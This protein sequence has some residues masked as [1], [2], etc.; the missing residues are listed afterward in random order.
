LYR[1]HRHRGI[2]AHT[3]MAEANPE[4]AVSAF[5]KPWRDNG[6]THK[7]TGNNHNKL[8]RTL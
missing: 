6:S 1:L 2:R 4:E 3:A 7:I 5:G 8:E